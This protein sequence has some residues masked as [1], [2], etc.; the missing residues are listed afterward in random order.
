MFA[1]NSIL[2][3]FRFDSTIRESTQ[4][5]QL[6]THPTSSQAESSILTHT[7][8]TLVDA[9]FSDSVISVCGVLLSKLSPAATQQGTPS[10]FETKPVEES[11][12]MVSSTQRNL[13]SL[14][15][16]VSSGSCVLLEGPV[17]CG[18]TALVGYLARE[19]GRKKPSQFMKIQLG[20]QTDSKVDFFAGTVL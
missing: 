8:H 2:Y 3:V 11:L 20:D 10:T 18:K 14:A 12:V 16:A 1:N 4:Q 6:L 17:G 9:D 5:A 19:T 7:L 13:R 15:L